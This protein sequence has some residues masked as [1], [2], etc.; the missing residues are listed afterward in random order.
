LQKHTVIT[1]VFTCILK[2][3]LLLFAEMDDRGAEVSSKSHLI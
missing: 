1:T 3:F 2:Q